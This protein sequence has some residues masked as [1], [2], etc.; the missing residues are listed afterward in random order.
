MN[1]KCT[2]F[3]LL[4]AMTRFSVAQSKTYSIVFLHKKADATQLSKA[5][6]DKIMEGHMANIKRLA[7]EGKLIVAGPFEGGGGIFIL[8]STSQEE[9]K[10]WLSADPGVQ[11]ERWT[12]EILPYT[13]RI[14][15][16]CAV[17]EPYEMVMYNF[18]RYD[19]IVSKFTASNYTE[20]L[21]KHDA[22]L[23]QL[24]QT[25]NIVTEAIFGEHD[26]GI[27]IIKGDLQKEVV[28]ADPGIQEGLL[29]F[30]VKKLYIAKGSF[31]EQ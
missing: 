18:I 2:L 16:L 25:G 21:R 11:A 4:I 5:E 12:V 28:E 14:G 22:Y 17:K 27:L 7:K 23:K 15:S 24:A 9:V 26:G 19:A 20:I 31:C 1:L 13:P 3:I 6:T 10:Q 8:K 30:D 29:E